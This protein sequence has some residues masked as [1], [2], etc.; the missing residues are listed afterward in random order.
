MSRPDSAKSISSLIFPQIITTYITQT[1]TQT[2]TATTTNS[3]FNIRATGSSVNALA[4]P[5]V[6][7]TNQIYEYGIPF[8]GSTPASYFR[9]DADCSLCRFGGF[10]GLAGLNA[11][12]QDDHYLLFGVFHCNA[13]FPG[14]KPLKCYVS[15][16]RKMQCVG[17][18]GQ[19]VSSVCTVGRFQNDFVWSRLRM[20]CVALIK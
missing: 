10:G 13:G 17:P 15:S 7:D 5:Q 9:L 19:T 1:V 3:Y 14:C 12:V 8:D 11:W 20:W 6:L 18:E 2:Q 16:D 4:G